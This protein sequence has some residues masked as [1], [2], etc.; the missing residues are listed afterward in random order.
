MKSIA[1]DAHGPHVATSNFSFFVCVGPLES[2]LSEAEE[3]TQA[4]SQKLP[5]KPLQATHANAGTG[6]DPSYDRH[7]GHAAQAA[8]S[9]EGAKAAQA[10][11]GAEGA[12]AAQAIKPSQS[13]GKW[14]CCSCH[15]FGL[16][17]VS[18]LHGT[19]AL[20]ISTDRV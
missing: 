13:S 4:S 5:S 2:K 19:C 8:Q 12:K 6:S 1:C 3:E 16:S 9:A 10:A 11:Q 7:V 20:S 18:C 17:F 15:V 14:L